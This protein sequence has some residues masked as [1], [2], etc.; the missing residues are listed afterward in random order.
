MPVMSPVWRD[1]VRMRL[2][3]YLATCLRSFGLVWVLHQEEFFRTLVV[4]VMGGESDVHLTFK[5]WSFW[6]I[7]NE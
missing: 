4:N 6:P 7:G 3:A 1:L 2:L 5:P